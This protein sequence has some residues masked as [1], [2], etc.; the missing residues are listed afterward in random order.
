MR[1]TGINRFLPNF[2]IC[3]YET[4]NVGGLAFPTVEPTHWRA[5]G[6]FS[7]PTSLRSS[8]DNPAQQIARDRVRRTTEGP[9]T[10]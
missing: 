5:F 9:R 2:P 7:A 6:D 8:G 3:V 1:R 10:P 4:K